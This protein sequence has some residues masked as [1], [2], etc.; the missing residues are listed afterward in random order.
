MR[1]LLIVTTLMLSL[2]LAGCVDRASVRYGDDGRHYR[3]YREGPPPHAPA[4]GYRAKYH[5]H[6]MVYDSRVRAY[7]VLGY[8]GYYYNDGWYFRYSDGYWQISADLGDRDWRKAD[9]Y[10][11]PEGLRNT[12]RGRYEYRDS[13]RYEKK[14]RGYDDHPG[15]GNGRDKNNGRGNGNS[16]GNNHDR[17][18][19][20]DWD[21]RD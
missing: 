11:V 18:R 20:R 4:H 3:D 7:V 1:I 5:H 17:D 9:Y 8:D 16:Q 2:S 14:G 12:K 21:D 15:K 13:D 10:R 19:D 6:D